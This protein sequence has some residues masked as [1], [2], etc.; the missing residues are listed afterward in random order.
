M[1]WNVQVVSGNLTA[2]PT[3]RST[4][5]GKHVATFTVAA[6]RKIGDKEVASFIRCVAWD[7]LADIAQQSLDKGT[8]VI[9]I[10]AQNTRSYNDNDGRKV[11]ITE[12][13]VNQ[14]GVVPRTDGGMKEDFRRG[15]NFGQFGNAY[16][17][18]DIPF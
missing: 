17:E 4:T 10:G 14:I 12:L 9:I 1:D 16:A 11:Y 6:N 7:Y 18:E 8:R 2:A 5:S 15:G 13:N 3:V